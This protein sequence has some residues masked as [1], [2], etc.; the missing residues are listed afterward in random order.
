MYN[1]DIKDVMPVRDAKVERYSIS[2]MVDGHGH[3][4][5]LTVAEVN[6]AG[7]KEKQ[8]TFIRKALRDE[9]LRCNP[10]LKVGFV[11]VDLTG[12]ATIGDD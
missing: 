9:H 10:Q 2:G 5:T 7:N 8:P 11:P 4:I 12:A 3:K 1:V 6:A